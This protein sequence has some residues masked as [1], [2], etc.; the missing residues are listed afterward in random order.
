MTPNEKSSAP[1]TAT[2]E[3]RYG[4]LP[5]RMPPIP[6]EKLTD[7]QNGKTLPLAPMPQQTRLNIRVLR[8]QTPKRLRT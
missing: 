8:G 4:V 2:S 5:D 3:M 6:P 7:A 1:S